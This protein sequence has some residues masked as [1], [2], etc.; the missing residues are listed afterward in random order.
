MPLEI[1]TLLI[2]WSRAAAR[3]ATPLL[4]SYIT[5]D[6]DRATV[7]LR[8]FACLAREAKIFDFYYYGPAYTFFDH[9]SDNASMVR[10]VAELTRDIGAADDVLWE[11]RAPKAEAALLYSQSWPV[12]K[13][14]D[15]EQ[16]EQMMAYVALLHAG[17]PVDIVSDAEVADGRF[18]ARRYKCLYV[19]NESV[20]AAAAAAIERW[21]ARRRANCGPAGGRGCGTSTTPRPTRGTRCSA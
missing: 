21:V 8:T 10:G 7:K 15:T 12:W 6:A 14:D 18:A 11:G 16:C 3:P 19:V 13:G 20:P 9:W 4:G 5:R 2:D 1:D 17:V